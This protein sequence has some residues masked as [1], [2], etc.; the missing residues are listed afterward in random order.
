[1]IDIKV[2]QVQMQKRCTF[3]KI[4]TYYLNTYPKIGNL[5]LNHIL[6][7][8]I[9]E[10]KYLGYQKMCSSARNIRTSRH[11][12]FFLLKISF[13]KNM[14]RLN[15]RLTKIGHATIVG[16]RQTDT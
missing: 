7:L 11:V 13:V 15:V 12:N 1:M 9:S 5:K 3:A 6:Q 2:I 4:S 14:R 8:T 10:N 16:G